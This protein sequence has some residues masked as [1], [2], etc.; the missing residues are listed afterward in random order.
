MSQIPELIGGFGAGAAILDSV[1]DDP[2]FFPPLADESAPADT[3]IENE[4]LGQDG[5]FLTNLTAG[6][7][8]EDSFTA[9]SGLDAKLS[10][11]SVDR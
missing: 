8:T 3:P 6:R 10:T 2:V 5:K 11:D 9:S 1:T 4:G 7:A